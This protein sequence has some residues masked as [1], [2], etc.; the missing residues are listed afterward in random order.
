MIS[1][2]TAKNRVFMRTMILLVVIMKISSG[3]V[4]A[5]SNLNYEHIKNG[6]I[7]FKVFT[8]QP[9]FENGEFF[10]RST[11]KVTSLDSLDWAALKLIKKEEWIALLNNA[12]FDWAANLILYALNE[13]NGYSFKK[14]NSRE[15]WLGRLKKE[16]IAYWKNNLK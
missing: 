13:R 10:S 9:D 3:Q 2:K 8:A 4:F 11:V 6:C 14:I 12:N 15:Q 7:K 5:Q 16:D 1:G